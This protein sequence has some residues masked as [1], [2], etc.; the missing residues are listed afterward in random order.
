VLLSHHLRRWVAISLILVVAGGLPTFTGVAHAAGPCDA[1][2][3]SVIECENSKPGS[4]AS[5]WDVAGAGSPALQGFA[6]DISF[7]PGETVRFKIKTTASAYHADIYRMGYY[8]GNGAR[9]VATVTPSASLPQS[10]PAC[11]NDTTTGLVDCGNWAVSATWS[12]PADAVSG[13]YFAKLIRDDGTAGSSHVVFV[14][15]DDVRNTDLLFQTSDTTWQ[16]YN[17]YG[18]NSLYKGSP[19]GRAYKV[20]YNRPFNNRTNLPDEWVFSAEYPMVRFLEANGYDVSYTTG[21]DSDRRGSEILDHKAFLSVGH[22]EYW[23]GA[24]RANVE[25][26]RDAGVHL[27]FFS[28]NEIFWKTR[29]ES[30]ISSSAAAH[31]T[32]VS[33]KES[34]ANAKIDPHPEW[35]GT[36]R[37]PR[38]SPPSDG[39]RPEN[40]LTGTI[41]TVNGTRADSIVV[42]HDDGRMRLWR[43]TNIATQA[44]GGSV[45]LP[46]GTLGFEWDSDLDNGARPAGLIRMSTATVDVTKHLIMDYCCTFAAGTPTHHLTLYRAPSGALVFG[47][48]TVQWSW[49]L[50]ATHDSGS[51]PADARMQQATVNLF[52]DMDVQ[53]ATLVAGLVPA[54]ASTDSTPP[55][56]ATSA[57]L[58]GA[59]LPVNQTATVTGT[60]AD[61]GG[62]VVGGV[63]MSIHGG[64]T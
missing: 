10:Q 53:P 12:V 52:A 5:V 49:G 33:Y 64:A 41:F 16:A 3:Q 32:L 44:P 18:G 48:G 45:T 55:Q 30:S 46:A 60:A 13:I 6:T 26:A 38:F 7:A 61:T 40:G 15:R 47:A 35:T 21:V 58:N 17:D 20:S 43:N 42:P 62:G 28:G 56:A 39:G 4:P 54:S 51:T 31:R 11:L 19:A 34:R 29:W 63:Q 24:Q 36:W 37:D 27:A 25:A 8:A 59:T 14:V 50:D 23:S 22:D 2:V 1:P 9:K 57:P